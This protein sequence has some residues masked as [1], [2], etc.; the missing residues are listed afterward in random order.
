MKLLLILNENPPGAHSD[1]HHSLNILKDEGVLEDFYVFPF[2]ARLAGGLK[3][4]DVTKEIVNIAKNFLP[5][6]PSR[7]RSFIFIN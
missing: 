6:I 2:L 5:F 4:N 7:T 3:D 1:V